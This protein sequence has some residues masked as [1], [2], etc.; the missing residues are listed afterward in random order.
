MS[1]SGAAA[2]AKGVR[3]ERDVRRAWEA[4]GLT[5]RGLEAEGDH[6]IVSV[7]G[8]VISSECKR[9]ERLKIP[10]W[11]RQCSDDAPAGSV[12]VLTFRQ[13]RGEMLSV[14]RTRDLARLAGRVSQ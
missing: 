4:A 8:L 11:W 10:E 6:L 3:F 12:P 7:D 1:A 5:V 13:S 9:Q 14:I 2:A